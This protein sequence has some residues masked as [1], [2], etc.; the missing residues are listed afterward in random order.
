MKALTISTKRPC[1]GRKSTFQVTE[2]LPREIYTRR[3]L[4]CETTYEIERRTLSTGDVRIDRLDW[5]DTRSRSHIRTYN[6]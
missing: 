4:A 5:E 3:C 1:C 6:S 2:S